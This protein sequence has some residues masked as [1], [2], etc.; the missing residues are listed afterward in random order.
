MGFYFVHLKQSNLYSIMKYI[1]IIIMLLASSYASGQGIM[2][3]DG[4]ESG[5]PDTTFKAR[6][7]V[8]NIGGTDFLLGTYDG[9]SGSIYGVYLRSI[10]HFSYDFISKRDSSLINVKIRWIQSM[11]I[12]L[13][14]NL[15]VIC[16][17]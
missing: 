15:M 8:Y 6:N 1:I 14:I 12:Q 4:V 7:Q 10:D 5:I 16:H 3:W 2:L 17:F 9:D 13:W 11:A